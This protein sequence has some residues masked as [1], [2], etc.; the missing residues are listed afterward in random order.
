MTLLIVLTEAD[1]YD[2]RMIG[3]A[4]VPRETTETT[5]LNGKFALRFANYR[6]A[7]STRDDNANAVGTG[8]RRL[9]RPRL[10]LA[11]YVVD[12]GLALRRRRRFL[13]LAVLDR[14]AVHALR[15]AG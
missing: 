2:D 13:A 11:E 3:R 12:L 10:C 6:A 1:N 7:E 8:R 9:L 15:S 14:P 5:R 4:I